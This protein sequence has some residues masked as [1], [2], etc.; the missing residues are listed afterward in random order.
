MTLPGPATLASL[1]RPELTRGA[2]TS[3]V[4]SPPWKDNH[5]LMFYVFHWCTYLSADS[6]PGEAGSAGVGSGSVLF[7]PCCSPGAGCCLSDQLSKV[8]RQPRLALGKLV[9]TMNDTFSC[10]HPYHLPASFSVLWPIG[11]VGRA[12][13]RVLVTIWSGSAASPTWSLSRVERLPYHPPVCYSPV[14]KADTVL[15]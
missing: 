15:Y 14:G 2:P 10:P 9:L 1:L 11:G 4:H 8:L 6:P 12:G 13:V 5:C 3:P 7:A